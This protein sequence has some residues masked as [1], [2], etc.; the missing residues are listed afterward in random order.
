MKNRKQ[1]VV[2]NNKTSLSEVDI[3]G[4]PQGSIDGPLLCNFFINNIMISLFLYTI[5]L[6]NYTG[7]KNPY[8]I[9]NDKEETKRALVKNFQTVINWF[10]KNYKIL[11][12]GK[13]DYKDVDENKTLQISSQKK[14][15]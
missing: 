6:G 12:I 15:D 10:H 9:S 14:G 4:V 13:R 8:S 1:K 2:K 11:N 3:A 7:D 5:V